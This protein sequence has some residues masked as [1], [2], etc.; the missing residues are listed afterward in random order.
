VRGLN[1]YVLVD[2][3]IKFLAYRIKIP[4]FPFALLRAYKSS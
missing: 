1:G 2:Y 4:R 3:R